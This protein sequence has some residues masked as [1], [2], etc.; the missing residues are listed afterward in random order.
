MTAVV[1]KLDN[2]IIGNEGIVPTYFSQNS[3]TIYSCVYRFIFSRLVSQTTNVREN[4]LDSDIFNA[5]HNI[6]SYRREMCCSEES[7]IVPY[8]FPTIT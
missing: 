5:F 7:R 2:T 1:S 6:I 8:T 3:F 4:G